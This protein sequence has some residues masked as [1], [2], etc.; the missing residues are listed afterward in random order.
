[1]FVKYQI[2]VELVS[3]LL[4]H[5]Y[6]GIC[7]IQGNFFLYRKRSWSTSCLSSVDYLVYWF[8][9]SDSFPHLTRREGASCCM[10]LRCPLGLTHSMLLRCCLARQDADFTD[11]QWNAFLPSKDFVGWSNAVMM[12]LVMVTA[13]CVNAWKILIPCL[14][15]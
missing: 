1:M 12:A 3:A 2:K 14:I 9:S 4:V 6:V 8:Y 7:C 15:V 5:Q 11:C 13:F 10:V